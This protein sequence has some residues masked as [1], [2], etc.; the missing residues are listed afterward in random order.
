MRAAAALVALAV[1]A[2][3][4][5]RLSLTAAE[6]D[7]SV[8]GAA[9]IVYRFFTLWANTLVGVVCG[10]I[11]LGG[12]PPQW[13]TAGLVLAITLVASVY[14]ALLAASLDFMGIEK[15]IDVMLHTVIPLA[16]VAIWIVLFPKHGLGWAHLVPWAALPIL[17]CLYALV[18]GALD[19]VYPYF[20]LDVGRLGASGVALWVAGLAM[21]FVA[22]GVV[23][24]TA[25][26]RTARTA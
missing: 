21:L 1:F 17:Y 8:F 4:A 18:R 22:A 2:T 20:F 6:N 15:V 7:T 12:R 26:R 14:H 16:Y 25:T 13:V 11:A 24:I 9:W 10:W 19:G 3:L 5:T 23:L